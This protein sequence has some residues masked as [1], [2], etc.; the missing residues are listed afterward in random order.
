MNVNAI[1]PRSSGESHRGLRSRLMTMLAV[2]AAVIVVG[3]APISEVR[4]P[5]THVT[6]EAALTT[7]IVQASDIAEA[8]RAVEA[9]GAT[10]V[11]ELGII[12]AV[13]A[14]MTEKQRASLEELDTIRLYADRSVELT[15]AKNALTIADTAGAAPETF[16]PTVVGADAVHAEGIDGSGVTIAVVDTGLWLSRG[17][18]LDADGN[19]RVIGALDL[20]GDDDAE[21]LRIASSW[22]DDERNAP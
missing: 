21:T 16:Y 1:N 11:D 10:V 3:C 17:V 9:V 22:D 20:V 12:N 19:E 15:D 14:A 4:E 13:T 2:L 6:A 18:I 5:V 7:W 8:Q